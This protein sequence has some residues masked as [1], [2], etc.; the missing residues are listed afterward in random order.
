MKSLTL[1]AVFIIAVLQI[2]TINLNA[3]CVLLMMIAR[4]EQ[5]K[6]TD[7][8]MY[9]EFFTLFSEQGRNRFMA[10]GWAISYFE[11]GNHDTGAGKVWF[12]IDN[13]EEYYW[14][15]RYSSVFPVWEDSLNYYTTIHHLRENLD[16]KILLSHI[17]Q[18][19]F[20]GGNV[21]NPHPFVMDINNS[22]YTFAHNGS[23]PGQQAVNDMREVVEGYI[24]AHNWDLASWEDLLT[25]P[26]DSAVY[27]AFIMAHIKFHNWDVVRGM[28]DALQHELI[29]NNFWTGKNFIF[30]DGYDV[31][32]YRSVGTPH[33]AARYLLEYRI[34][35]EH[36][37]RETAVI[38]TRLP[39]SDENVEIEVD[40]L[41]YIPHNGSPVH[42]KNICDEQIHWQLDPKPRLISTRNY[43]TWNSFPILDPNLGIFEAPS[44][45]TLTQVYRPTGSNVGL[46]NTFE[47]VSE[48]G[49]SIHKNR[50]THQWENG[51]EPLT[52][53]NH[54]SG[55]KML[56]QGYDED[57]A[58]LIAGELA[59]PDITVTLY[60]GRENWTGYW[61]LNSQTVGQ[62]ITGYH[63]QIKSVSAVD[64]AHKTIRMSSCPDFPMEFGRM[65]KIKLFDRIDEPVEF[66]WHNSRYP[67]RGRYA[68]RSSYFSYQQYSDY[69]VIDIEKI[70]GADDIKEVGVF[71]NN[72]CIGAAVQTGFPLQ[73]LIYPE[74]NQG[75]EIY[76]KFYHNDSRETVSNHDIKIWNGQS[77]ERRK[78]IA[79]AS[80]YKT[81]RL[82]SAAEYSPGP[83][84]TIA[85]ATV[86]PNPFNPG[87][88][89]F[90]E[91]E[92]KSEVSIDI[93]NAKGQKIR[94]LFSG[95]QDSGRSAYLWD[96]RNDM[97]NQ[98][99][100]GVY[101]YRIN[102]E[103]ETINGKMLML[104]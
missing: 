4:N 57:S 73:L 22:S 40:E 13:Q 65:Y 87:T 36:S 93:F 61:L 70:T 3:E 28:R 78:L 11:E 88:T 49:E 30:S 85:A 91:F 25:S 98:Q 99:P 26:V 80:D 34:L 68:R 82:V 71:A 103:G 19:T 35:H 50:I 48:S 74:N 94:K 7:C 14:S 84:G 6:I 10:D 16:S 83:S 58:A 44:I 60:P 72:T 41:V 46:D 66:S 38:M 51:E 17:R 97:N 21:P 53:F 2:L 86:S 64:W 55:Y 5:G 37:D 90:L 42:F 23:A 15:N 75:E 9:E 32:A 43:R 20:G 76:F 95:T 27:F 24:D 102:A 47:V 79:G 29:N 39:E 104:K 59:P 12:D 8:D 33:Q 69:Q 18:A 77:Y 92:R 67:Q 96:G 31:Y 89:I 101:F 54:T 63:H 1:I 45:E 62:A 56:Q 81:I 52:H 100:N